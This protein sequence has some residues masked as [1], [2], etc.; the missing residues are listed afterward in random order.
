MSQTDAPAIRVGQLQI[1]YLRDG[2]A[3]GTA[4]MFELTVPP[5]AKSPPAHSHD[6][7]EI[8]YGLEGVLRVTVGDEIREVGPGQCSYTPPGVTH[9]FGNPHDNPARVL[10]INT[11]DIGAQYFRDV[12]EAAA[13]PGGPDPARM[14]E[15]MLRY[16]LRL[17]PPKQDA[18]ASS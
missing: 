11:P 17:T 5:G 6:N 10:V 1:R 12:A 2:S 3:D 4:G 18:P 8:L 7:E 13:G 16:G 14:G 15:V 9:G